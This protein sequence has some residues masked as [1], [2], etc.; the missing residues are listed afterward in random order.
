MPLRRRTTARLS[1]RAFL[2]GATGAGFTLAFA[3]PGAVFADPATAIA[4]NVFEPTIWYQIDRD[5]IV[6]VNI[7]R[8]EMG[9]H[10]G[11]ALARIVAD[12]L[13]ADWSSVRINGVDTDPKWG[14]D[15]HRRQLVGV[16][17]LRA[18]QPGRRGRPHR[19]DRR[20]RQ[21][22]RRAERAPASPGQR[23]CARQQ[24]RS[25]TAT[26]CAEAI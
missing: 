2:I 10:V 22:A 7:I 25:A 18:A 15:G 16:A 13:E 26:S 20:R 11:T 3:R 4:D 5:G 1:R 9:Q 14:I 12:E 6:T 8:A 17:E 19:A 21:V 23:R 24:G